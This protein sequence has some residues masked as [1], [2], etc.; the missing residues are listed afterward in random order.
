MKKS[1][2]IR[3]VEEVIDGN[4]KEALNSDFKATAHIDE[5]LLTFLDAAI[6]NY[7]LSN[8][9]EKK[10]SKDYLTTISKFMEDLKKQF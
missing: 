3:L 8:K 7:I 9:F 5:K 6:I 1:E 4:I 2:L 10:F